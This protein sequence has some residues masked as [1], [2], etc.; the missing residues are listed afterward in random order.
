MHA[1]A[2]DTQPRPLPSFLIR[3]L[4]KNE[5]FSQEALI[6]IPLDSDLTAKVEH[7]DRERI[8]HSSCVSA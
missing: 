3:G 4:A 7:D 8:G 2:P 5:G 6:K 1:G